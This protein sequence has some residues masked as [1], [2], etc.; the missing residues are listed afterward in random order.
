MGDLELV[1]RHVQG[2]TVVK[3]HQ[4]SEIKVIIIEKCTL[5]FFITFSP[6]DFKHPI[7]LTFC[8]MEINFDDIHNNLSSLHERFRTIAKNLVACSRFFHL[9]VQL[10]IEI[11]LHPNSITPGLFRCTSA[12]YGTVESQARLTLHLHLLLWICGSLSPQ[13]IRDLLLHDPAYRI[14]LVTWLEACIQAEF[15]TG[16]YGDIANMMEGTP[17]PCMD[18]PKGPLPNGADGE[19][20]SWWPHFLIQVDEIAF[21]SQVHSHGRGCKH[22]PNGECKSRFPRDL[23]EC[24]HIDPE[25]GALLL[26]Q[27]EL[28]LTGP[29]L[30]FWTTWGGPY[31]E[32]MLVTQISIACSCWQF[33]DLRDGDRHR[34]WNSLLIHER[35]LSIDTVFTRKQ[36]MSWVIWTYFMS[37]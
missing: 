15:T 6:V 26:K 2:S 4:R 31:R 33:F 20:K 23:Y 37:V 14:H 17:D 25:T 16:S 27:Q 32:K 29:N 28:M 12:Y 21:R 7:C 11:I 5:M 30:T 13:K 19:V 34:N 1:N 8:G 18:L 3:R 10:F 24:T 35:S 36:Y 22:G 9:M